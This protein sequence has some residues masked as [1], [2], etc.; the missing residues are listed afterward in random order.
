MK[1]SEEAWEELTLLGL[2]PMKIANIRN[3]FH[4]EIKEEYPFIKIQDNKWYSKIEQ[5]KSFIFATK[6]EVILA[7]AIYE[8]LQGKFNSNEFR[9]HLKYTFRLLGLKSAWSGWKDNEED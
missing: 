5:I 1:T 2:K 7:N 6:K 9:D 4:A 3:A 8:N